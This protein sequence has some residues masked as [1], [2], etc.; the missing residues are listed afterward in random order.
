M[1]GVNGMRDNA[2][3]P[4]LSTVP[5]FM[6]GK[7]GRAGASARTVPPPG[8]AHTRTQGAR[9]IAPVVA[10]GSHTL[11][12]LPSPMGPHVGVVASGADVA[13]SRHGRLARHA[14]RPAARA[15]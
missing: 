5:W 1:V 3:S 6:A 10:R 9:Q 11:H 14:V 13:L 12:L 4:L 7:A 15:V 8:G 2:S